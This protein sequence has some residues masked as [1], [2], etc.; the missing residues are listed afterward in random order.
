VDYWTD[1]GLNHFPPLSARR[2]DAYPPPLQAV[3][4]ERLASFDHPFSG[5]TANGSCRDGLFTLTESAGDTRSLA[6]AAQAFLAHLSPQQREQATF[7]LG[8]DERRRWINVH[9]YI[10]RH[11]VMLEDLDAAGRRL[12]ID[13]LRQTL[14]Y[15]GFAQARDIMRTNRLLADVTNSPDEFGEWPYFVSIFGDPA[16]SEPWGW[17][18]DGHHLCLNC[19]VVG[20]QVVLTP[21]F[22]GAE[23]SRFLDGPLAGTVLFSAEERGGL[24]LI[25]SLDAGQAARAI[26]R[27]SIHPDDLPRELQHPFDGR[28]QGGAYH[29]NAVVPYEGVP[30][31]DLSDAQR[32]RLLAVVAAYVGWSPEPHAEIKMAEVVAHLDETW[33]SWM[34]GTGGDDPFYYRV[35]SPVVMIEFDH[36]PGVAFDNR[37]PSRNHVH[38]VLRT[39]NGNDYGM[40]LLR[41]H[42]DRYDHRHGQ[43]TSRS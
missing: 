16:T 26:L 35:Q 9:M 7:P 24:A 20:D 34:G 23:P 12:G 19:T 40:D 17:Q 15:R 33:F 31:A 22:M 29:D 39:P 8:A 2:P 21:T 6:E 38:T 25:R 41:Q 30:G 42:H 36:H 11:G 13:L 43:H 5:I 3:V 14:S 28:M 10:F 18:I 32:R 4:D 1:Y 37:V 27:P